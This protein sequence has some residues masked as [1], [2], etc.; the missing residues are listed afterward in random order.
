[1]GTGTP[2]PGMGTGTPSTALGRSPCARGFQELCRPRFLPDP[3]AR[4][5]PHLQPGISA[6][7]ARFPPWPRVPS[8]APPGPWHL[9]LAFP[10]PPAQSRS[11]A[12]SSRTVPAFPGVSRRVLAPKLLRSRPQPSGRRSCG[13]GRLLVPVSSRRRCRCPPVPR[14]AHRPQ[15]PVPGAPL[16]LCRAEPSRAELSRA[17][18][19]PVP[20]HRAPAWPGPAPPRGAAQPRERHRGRPGPAP[21]HR[22]GAPGAG[23]GRGHRGPAPGGGTGVRHRR[24]AEG[25]GGGGGK[26][27]PLE[28]G[29]QGGAHR[30]IGVMSL[31]VSAISVMSLGGSAW[32]CL[33]GKG[34]QGTRG[35]SGAAPG[36]GWQ[37]LGWG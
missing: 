36:Q 13:G 1:M 3:P 2:R 26:E 18:P 23:T 34:S 21:P 15:P 9:P 11:P 25:A 24:G 6:P 10:A 16:P 30:V 37:S 12:R 29:K 31:R 8:S 22:E 32:V 27:P 17:E 28:G 14:P 4:F 5:S 7:S 35:L 33:H 19:A 20:P